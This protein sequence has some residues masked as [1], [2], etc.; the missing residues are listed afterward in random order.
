[1]K[2]EGE[3]DMVL[4]A[5]LGTQSLRAMIIDERGET[6]IRKKI[7]FDASRYMKDGGIAEEDPAVYWEALCSACRGIA[8]E[9]PDLVKTV[10][11]MS[12]TTFRDSVVCLD[13]NGEPLRK[14]IL[15]LD[16]RTTDC[17]TLKVPFLS[18]LAFKLIGFEST[19]HAQ[20]S[21]T[22]SNWII[23]H[24]PE[25]WEKTY[26][27]AFLPTYLMHR[28]TGKFAD[29][30]ASQIGH[31]PL[32]YKRRKWKKPNDI[33]M[34]VY[35]V[36][37]EKLVDLVQPGDIIG[38][39]T[40]K[41]SEETGLPE[42]LP[43]IA[44]GSDKSCESLGCGVL[45]EDVASISLGTA[46]TVQLAL[47]G[48]YVE[49]VRFLPAYP[50][51]AKG[52]YNPE[53]QIYR[54]FWM[55]RWFIENFGKEESLIAEKEGVPTEVVLN[56]C[57]KD[58]PAG[59]DGLVLQPYWSPLLQYPEARGSV[60]GFRDYHTKAHLY[61]AIIEGIGYALRDGLESM[62]KRSGNRIKWATISGGSSQSDEI[63]RIMADILGFPVRRIQTYEACGLG[64]ALAVY[65]AIGKFGSY[66]EA[67][68]NM[69]R[70]EEP[71]L[72][73]PKNRAVYDGIYKGV[74]KDLYK[75]LRPLYK[76]I[77]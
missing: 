64:C 38:R 29:S 60:V 17:H 73:D 40:K 14:A 9:R 24:E 49:P 4:V 76:S 69:V 68:K 54:G 70:Y 25:I 3:K 33:Q 46:A 45:S 2:Y 41:A 71:F 55:L 6:L 7:A 8:E 74:Y 77:Y 61:R 52:Y 57:L 36:P 65:V 21:I 5:D 16:Q 20:R 67:V 59:C 34:S 23:E 30:V 18:S 44:T 11:A 37:A 27:F 22:K 50:S 26:K 35:N 48:R 66:E 15:W 19:L 10:E 75:Q 28:L 13:E 62:E 58:T 72:P 39:V 51:T 12:V 63:C 32:D 1:M 56:R 53:V 31:L 43:I 47:K 42:G